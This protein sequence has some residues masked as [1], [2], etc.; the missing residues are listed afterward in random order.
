MVETFLLALQMLSWLVVMA[1]S[2]NVS[3]TDPARA[4]V[5]AVLA[6][7]LKPNWIAEPK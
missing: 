2:V 4:L 6:F 5:Y 7:A 1:V 3:F